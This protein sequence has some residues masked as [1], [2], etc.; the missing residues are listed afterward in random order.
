MTCRTDHYGGGG[1]DSISDRRVIPVALQAAQMAR[2]IV[3]TP[4]GGLPEV[5]VHREIGA[6]VEPEG[7]QALAAATAPLLE[8]P[9]TA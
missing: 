7:R 1:V 5:V 6:L 4:V 9:E 2:P 3:A 8:Q